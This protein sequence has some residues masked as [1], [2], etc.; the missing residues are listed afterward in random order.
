M[1]RVL[2]SGRGAGASST[3]AELH[4]LRIRCKRLRYA[5]EFLSDLYGPPVKKFAMRVK[6]LQ[7]I[8]GAHQDAVVAQ[9]TLAKFTERISAGESEARDLYGA[10][11]QLMAVQAR[12]TAE[13]R[14]EF[15][16]A[17]ERFDRVKVRAPLEASLEEAARR[18]ETGWRAAKGATDGED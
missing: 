4:R 5:C 8:L 13:C 9:R 10:V 14:A 7:D 6:A 11:G 16:D 2:K 3:D 17:W 12:R 18:A 1:K 15:K